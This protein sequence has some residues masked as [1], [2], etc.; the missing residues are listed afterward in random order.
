MVK[1][2]VLS[3]KRSAS[4]DLYLAVQ[5]S[6]PDQTLSS[7]P[8]DSS[9]FVTNSF[10]MKVTSASGNCSRNLFKRSLGSSVGRMMRIRSFTDSGPPPIFVVRWGVQKV[11]L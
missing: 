10:L 8:G 7:S 11:W 4:G 1:S 2:T 6:E 5:D 9:V 3:R